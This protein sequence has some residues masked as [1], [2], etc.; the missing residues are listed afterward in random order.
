M[1]HTVISKY[2]PELCEDGVHMR[3]NK[4]IIGC[5]RSIVPDFFLGSNEELSVLSVRSWFVDIGET[6]LDLKYGLHS[7]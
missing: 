1:N 3:I 6:F 7:S 2:V 5:C 4:P